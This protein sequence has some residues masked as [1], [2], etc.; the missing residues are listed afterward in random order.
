MTVA[1]RQGVGRRERGVLALI[2]LPTFGLALAST[3]V[4]TYMP[5]LLNELSGPLVTGLLIGCEGFFGMWVP[6]VVGS[7]SDSS[8]T[9]LGPRLPFVLA[10][11]PGMVLAIV[12]MPFASTLAPLIALLSLFFAAYFAYYTPYRAVYADIVPDEL[13]GRSQ[14]VQKT[15]REAGLGVALVSGGVLLSVWRPL[16]FLLAAAVLT[17]TTAAFVLWRVRSRHDWTEANAGGS[18]R[19]RA[20]AIKDLLAGDP[21]VRWVVIGNALWEG[22][23]AALKTFVV[24]FI[25]VGLGRSAGMASGILAIVAVAAVVGALAGGSLAD[26]VGKL[27]VMR[28]AIWIYAIGALLPVFVHSPLVIAGVVPV[29]VAAAV[30]MTLPYALLMDNAPDSDHGLTAGLFD[31]SRGIGSLAGPLAAGVAITLLEPV[32]ADTQGYGAMFLVVSLFCFASLYAL[33]RLRQLG[34]APTR[35][36]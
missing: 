9:R 19:G 33:R 12:L 13:S 21:V 11:A 24:L 36:G 26:R 16:P 6:L 31:M 5:V 25:T 8:S 1:E 22:T 20:R 10:A 14:G 27:P 28:V 4:T 29:A 17:A 7:W 15:L 23:I 30:V 35:S 2:A 18:L 34:E 3:I 32:L